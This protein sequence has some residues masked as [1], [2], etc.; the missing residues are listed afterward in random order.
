M[1]TSPS[2]GLWGSNSKTQGH[3]QA[4]AQSPFVRPCL[5]T[6][7]WVPS[8]YTR[9]PRLEVDKGDLNS[10]CTPQT[11]GA[12]STRRIRLGM[13]SIRQQWLPSRNCACSGSCKG[14]YWDLQDPPSHS[15]GLTDLDVEPLD[16]AGFGCPQWIAAAEAAQEQDRAGGVACSRSINVQIVKIQFLF[17]VLG[18]MEHD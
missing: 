2:C 6:Q 8:R 11:C 10:L 4:S 13:L 1:S 7:P 14:G 9:D 12:L 5:Y 16:G 17:I 18:A 3:P 15:Q